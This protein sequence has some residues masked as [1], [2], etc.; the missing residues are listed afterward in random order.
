M[1]R[2]YFGD[3]Y[4]VYYREGEGRYF[5]TEEFNSKEKLFDFCIEENIGSVE[6]L[7]D[8]IF[9]SSNNFLDLGDW[10]I[11]KSDFEFRKKERVNDDD[12]VVWLVNTKLNKKFVS[13]KNK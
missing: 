1:R 8:D 7:K 13:W 3:T 9:D 6:Q 4:E 5:L 10:I 11:L 12:G 2:L